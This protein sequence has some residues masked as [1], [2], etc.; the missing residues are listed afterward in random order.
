MIFKNIDSVLSPKFEGK[1]VNLHGWVY[2][3]REQ[4]KLIFIVLR[5]YSN[6]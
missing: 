2:R 5:D 3:K 6:R 4:K 1:K